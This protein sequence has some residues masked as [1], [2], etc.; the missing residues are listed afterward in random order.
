[1]PT[2]SRIGGCSFPEEPGQSCAFVRPVWS[3][4]VDPRV[5][6]VRA[7][8]PT[9]GKARLFDMAELDARVLWDR[10][11]EHLLINR[12]NDLF[13]LDVIEGTVAAGPVSLR[14]DLADDDRLSAQI[15]ALGRF[16]GKAATGHRHMQLAHRL[17]A[18]HAVDARDAGASLREVAD[19][20]LGPGAW[21]GNGE[22]RKSLVRR[23]IVAGDRM[24][25]AGPASA[26][27]DRSHATW[28][29]HPL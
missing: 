24:I 16:R 11:A 29:L 17:L 4:T 23:M 13:R 2:S 25:R 18:L 15:S 10:H 9:G 12:D 14:F 20:V 6:A 26:L 7:G 22:H 21:P 1:M 5:L 3:A 8:R 28:Q 27:V 19:V